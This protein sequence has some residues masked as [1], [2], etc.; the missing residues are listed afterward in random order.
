[1]YSSAAQPF[2]NSWVTTCAKSFQADMSGHD[3]AGF[4]TGGAMT[5]EP[6]WMRIAHSF[7]SWERLREYI[8]DV[9]EEVLAE[10]QGALG[11]ESARGLRER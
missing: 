6:F 3:I 10:L 4:V 2:Q 11:A 8:E 5:M 9:M 7:A 1:M